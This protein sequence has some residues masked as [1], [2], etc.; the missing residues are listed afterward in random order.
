MFANDEVSQCEISI[1]VDTTPG[2]YTL[3]EG[4]YGVQEFCVAYTRYSL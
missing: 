2:L 3:G 1:K 4:R